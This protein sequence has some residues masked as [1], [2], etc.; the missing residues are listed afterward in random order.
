VLNNCADIASEALR[1]GGLDLP[2]HLIYDPEQVNEDLQNLLGY[3]PAE[4]IAVDDIIGDLFDE[5]DC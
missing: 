4:G 5:D 2:S 1:E 3:F